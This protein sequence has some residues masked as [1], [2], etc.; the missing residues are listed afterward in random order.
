[1]NM[2]MCEH[3]LNDLYILINIIYC[4]KSS[5]SLDKIWFEDKIEDKTTSVDDSS[6]YCVVRNEGV[7]DEQN[8]QCS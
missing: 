2:S 3:G 4:C 8:I 5:H 1:M 6:L 7:G